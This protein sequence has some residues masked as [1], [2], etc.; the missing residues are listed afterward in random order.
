M[1]SHPHSSTTNKTGGVFNILCLN[2]QQVKIKPKQ[3][4]SPRCSG[5]TCVLGVTSQQLWF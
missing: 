1:R 3:G 5:T 4:T 2:E